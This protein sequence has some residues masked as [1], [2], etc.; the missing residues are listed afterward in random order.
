VRPIFLAFLIASACLSV[1]TSAFADAPDDICVKLSA[2]EN[3]PFDSSA[4]SP[5]RH[6]VEVHWIGNWLDLQNGWKLRCDHSADPASGEFCKWLLQNTSFEFADR[7][8]RAML[9]CHGYHFPDLT[10]WDDWRL[11]LP[12]SFNEITET[13]TLLQIDLTSH[14]QPESAVRYSVFAKGADQALNPL[15]PLITTPP[16]TPD[17]DLR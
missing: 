16:A 5:R 13:S 9:I 15:P 2:F 14:K 17:D 1:V 3:A 8:P 6:W 10:Y 11:E 7:L 12:L 4:N